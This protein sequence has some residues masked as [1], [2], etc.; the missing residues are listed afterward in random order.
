VDAIKPKP[1]FVVGIIRSGTSLLYSLLNQHPDIALMYECDIWDFP[2]MFSGMRFQRNWLERQEFYNSALSRH[3]LSVGDLDKVRT[4][5]D[6]YQSFNRGKRAIVWGEKSPFYCTRLLAL[7]RRF[8]G[9]SFILLWRDP[10]EICQTI[11]GAGRRSRFFRRAGMLSRLIYHQE[12]LIT[13]A[14]RIGCGG[15]R[16]HH[17]TYGDLTENTEA[18]CR[19]ICDFLGVEFDRRMLDLTDADFSAVYPDPPH[20]YLR[21]GIIERRR[22]AREALKPTALNTL[23][24]FQ[25]RWHRLAGEWLNHAPEPTAAPEPSVLERFYYRTTGRLFTAWDDCKRWLFEFLPLPWLRTYRQVKKW[26]TAVR[27]ADEPLQRNGLFDQAR[28]HWITLSTAW[29]MVA[30]AG[31][32]D[33]MVGS[34]FDVGSFYLVPVGLLTL[35]VNR[36]WGSVAAAASAMIGLI[37]QMPD[38]GAK[39]AFAMLIW[40]CLMRFIVLQAF[41]L[42]LDRIRGASSLPR[43]ETASSP[44]AVSEEIV[45]DSTAFT[46]ISI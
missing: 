42:L 27:L 34:A 22:D 25:T 4:P 11:K 21:R 2:R 46:D 26:F 16:V 6:L 31:F 10:V 28:A 45:S 19:A 38:H 43:V 12:Q 15:A 35:V 37:V 29:S 39:A 23:R 7:A 24:R 18:A 30:M 41:V 20:E 3:R 5:A 44:S 40:N 33:W 32:A 1:V 14:A 17:L 9:C 8:P 36:R 13:Q